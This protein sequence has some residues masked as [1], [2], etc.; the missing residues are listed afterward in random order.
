MLMACSS[1]MFTQTMF[2]A[3]TTCV[4]SISIG[5]SRLRSL[6]MRRAVS[7]CERSFLIFFVPRSA[8][9]GF[10]GWSCGKSRQGSLFNW[11]EPASCHFR[12]SMDGGLALGCA[13]RILPTSPTPSGFP[14]DLRQFFLASKGFVSICCGMNPIL[15]TCPGLKALRRFKNWGGQKRGSSIWAMKSITR[16]LSGHCRKTAI[17]LM[18]VSRSR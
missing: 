10:P 14:A 7:N 11:E 1:R 12:W 2:L 15:P 17:W 3:S 6:R 16:P 5:M 8:G 9:R 4:P 18:T 13:T